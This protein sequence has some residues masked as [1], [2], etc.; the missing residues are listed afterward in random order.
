MTILTSYIVE[1]ATVVLSNRQITNFCLYFYC[2]YRHGGDQTTAFL[3]W[4][5][6]QLCR[7]LNR[8]PQEI[9]ELQQRNAELTVAQLTNALATLLGET[10]LDYI[11]VD[12]IDRMQ[13]IE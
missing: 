1:Q 8:I 6:S 7:Q 2:S 12:A 10:G 11:I 9:S 5:V 4:V 3:K 13:H